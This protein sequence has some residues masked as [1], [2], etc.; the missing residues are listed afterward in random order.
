MLILL[1]V[2]LG[3]AI[4]L[5]LGWWVVARV[6]PALARLV[7]RA[8]QGLAAAAVLGAVAAAVAAGL[9]GEP[10]GIGLLSA[11]V[12]AP[13][14]VVARVRRRSDQAVRPAPA[15]I[16]TRAQRAPAPIDAP[17]VRLWRRK[18]ALGG[19]WDPRLTRAEA[20]VRRFIDHH[21]RHPFDPELIDYSPLIERRLGE[22]IDLAEAAS[23][24][25]RDRAERAAIRRRLVDAVVA[26]GAGADAR[27]GPSRAALSDRLATLVAH[28]TA[29]AS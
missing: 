20:Q 17:D 19:R 10:I 11:M 15:P 24:L 5:R 28:V 13:F 3:A 1:L 14:C 27:L 18:R 4:A 9:G 23:A 22:A 25:A 21:A 12:A 29:R 8:A 16:V 2:A 26:I 7:V 6:V